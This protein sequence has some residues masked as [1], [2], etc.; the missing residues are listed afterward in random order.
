MNTDSTKYVT[1]PSIG[2]G[3]S[4]IVSSTTS[5]T[6]ST[7]TSD[8]SELQSPTAESQDAGVHFSKLSGGLSYLEKLMVK[9]H[10][11]DLHFHIAAH[12][13]NEH[14][15]KGK[16]EASDG[17]EI[18][19]RDD[20][21]QVPSQYNLFHSEIKDEEWYTYSVQP[22]SVA[23]AACAGTV[24]PRPTSSVQI[25]E[26]TFTKYCNEFPSLKQ[27][28]DNSRNNLKKGTSNSKGHSNHQRREK[29][30]PSQRK[31]NKEK[32]QQKYTS[33]PC[34][35]PSNAGRQSSS[36]GRSFTNT[37]IQVL[38]HHKVVPTASHAG[39]KLSDFFLCGVDS[40]DVITENATGE[41]SSD[42][43]QETNSSR[44]SLPI[45]AS[46]WLPGNSVASEVEPT[47]TLRGD[48]YSL[49]PTSTGTTTSPAMNPLH[50]ENLKPNPLFHHPNPPMSST[51]SPCHCVSPTSSPES[52]PNSS[53]TPLLGT[54]IYHIDTD[55]PPPTGTSQ[56]IW[57]S[58]SLPGNPSTTSDASSSL[59][60]RASGHTDS[61]S[62]DEDVIECVGDYLGDGD[63][64]YGE[65]SEALDDLAWELQSLTAGRLTQCE[66][67]LEGECGG[68]EEEE[69][70]GVEEG[71]CGGVEE[72][73]AGIERVK[74]SFEIYH[75]QLM[76][77]DS[78]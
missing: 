74:S 14:C 2:T 22:S 13:Q 33:K 71:E 23:G 72:L 24:P 40:D 42:N 19:R 18:E 49:V 20:H 51:N 37:V 9:R 11:S 17:E 6:C 58:H 67:E 35:G 31:K 21:N 48:P 7:Q 5:Q 29:R 47:C 76:Q 60:R 16:G 59:G 4:T 70:G 64:G 39:E 45:S 44:L 50:S 57:C 25:E 27:N 54:S 3:A 78:D 38:K 68:V 55:L 63:E 28:N 62:D 30:H 65:D 61:E 66:G 77:Q 75:Q 56:H 53:Q 15:L 73:E 46:V 41:E 8:S 1:F 12:V 69:C 32:R 36:V 34:Q 10:C 26:V 52:S 43:V